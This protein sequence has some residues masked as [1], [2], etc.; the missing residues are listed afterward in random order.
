MGAA[1][2]MMNGV[3]IDGPLLSYIY[4][5]SSLLSGSKGVISMDPKEN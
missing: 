5:S 4:S 2:K 1:I 3:G